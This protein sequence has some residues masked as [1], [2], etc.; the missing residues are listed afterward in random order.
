MSHL[1]RWGALYVLVVLWLGSAVGQFAA[2]TAEGE[3]WVLFMSATFENWQS[4]FLQLAVQSLLIV[5]L[6]GKMFRVSKDEHEE[7]KYWMQRQLVRQYEAHD[8][9]DQLLEELRKKK[10]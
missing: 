9:L 3:G 5:G 2:Q 8:K 10:T 1:K 6:A 7:T 4:E